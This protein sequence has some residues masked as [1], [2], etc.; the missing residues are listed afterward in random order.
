MTRARIGKTKP[1]ALASLL[2]LAWATWW[3][4]GIWLDHEAKSEVDQTQQEVDLRLDGFVSDFDRSLAYVQSVP[5]VVAHEIVVGET[6]SAPGNDTTALNAYLRFV[7]NTMNVDLA[8]VIDTTG[9]CIASSNSDQADTLVGGRFSDREYFVAAQNGRRGVQYAV[10][11]RTNIPG[12]FYSTPIQHDGRFVGAAVVKIDVPNIEQAI[13]AKGAFVTD[14]HGVVIIAA[15]PEWLLQAAP[16][17]S[18]YALTSTEL[19][20]AYKR[21][22]IALLP[23]TRTEGEPFPFR[24]GAAATP[25]VLSRKALPTG[26]MTAYVLAPIDRLA[27]LRNKRFGVFAIVYAGLCAGL[28][29]TGLSLLMAKRSRAH[30]DHLL[31]AKEQ[32]E[33]G[34]RAKSEFLAT[35]S[36]EIRT[37]LNGIVG[38]TDL[39]LDSALNQEQRHCADTIQASAE[40]LLAIIN[41]I[42]EFS[43]MEAGR[44]D[45]ARQAFDVGQLV[46]GV[47]DILAPRLIGTQI[48]LASFVAPELQG[49]FLGDEGRIRQVLLNLVGNAIK[50]TEHGGVAVS[51]CLEQRAIRFEVT[52]TGIGIPNEAKPRL[53]SMFTQV[54]SS[55]TRRYGGTGLGLAISRR[56]VEAMGGTI[57]FESQLGSGSTFWFSIPSD[58]AGT[59]ASVEAGHLPL[60]GMRVLV[61]DDDPIM[62]DV[63]RLQ[64]ESIGGEVEACTEVTAGLAMARD[65]AAAGRRFDVAVLDNQMRGNTVCEMASMFC[66]DAALANTPVVLTTSAPT[67]ALRA[68][69]A[70]FGID[71]VLTKPVRQRILAAHLLEFIERKRSPPDGSTASEPGPGDQGTGF[72]ILVVDDVAINRRVAAGM[73][74]RLGHRIDVASDG[75]EA[76]ARVTD[77]DYDA[78]FMDIHMPRMNGI[79][80]TTAIRR[81]VG[82]KSRV[83]IFAMTANTLDGDRESLLAAGMN[84]YISKPFSL[85]KLAELLEDWRQRLERE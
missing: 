84:D 48:D 24:I 29:G 10:G 44:L 51:A 9:L 46:E 80:A 3:S 14:R 47:L 39:L 11:R 45:L 31:E 32:A 16:G 77:F 30:R 79:D 18:V 4:T 19:Q 59:P 66:S 36:H 22:S 38:M 69:A 49:S 58:R 42:L 63:L 74:T 1:A 65:A 41:D 61:F 57:G 26:D 37:P 76:V 54:D 2:L 43:R 6:L 21:D 53:F 33:A 13:F 20:L 50:F 52:D 78:V 34:S 12:L 81:F 83:P 8:F 60:G 67:A 85:A 17:A 75:I 71:V 5:L 62:T 25:A 55:T 56:I 72:Q 70:D 35:M 82:P 15:D 64:I 7:A 68:Q 23:I 40:A 27:A 28:W 73:L